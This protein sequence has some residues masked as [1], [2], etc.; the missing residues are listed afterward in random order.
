MI[1]KLDYF[2]FFFFFCLTNKNV[3]EYQIIKRSFLLLFVFI[4]F[5]LYETLDDV[6]IPLSSMAP[7]CKFFFFFFFCS[8]K[9]KKKYTKSGRAPLPG[10][11]KLHL[12]FSFFFLQ[13]KKNIGNHV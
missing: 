7:T 9:K 10:N 3:H 5:K 11:Q 6:L 4:K 13:P 1:E 2:F 8:K 12:F